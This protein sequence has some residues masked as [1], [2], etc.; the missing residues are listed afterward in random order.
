VNYLLAENLSKSFGEKLLFEDITF[1][2][3]KGQK[4]ALIARNGTGKSSLLNILTRK[5]YPDEGKV[6]Y[7]KDI[8]IAYLS[9]NP[10]LDDNSR[11]IDILFQSD[12]DFIAAIRDYEKCLTEAEDLNSD[13]YNEKL[14]K[15]IERMDLLHAW[16]YESL[17]KEILGKLNIGD[18]MQKVGQLSGGQK[19]KVALSKVLIEEVDLLILD[20][21][22]NHLDVE[23]IEWFEEYISKQNLSLLVVTHDRY[24][25]DNVCDEIIEIDDL[26]LFRYR[27]NY[28]YFLEK[29]AERI[30]IEEREIEK[31]RNLYR[32][33]LE[34][35]RR[36]PKA[37]ATKAKSRIDS[38]YDIQE[39]ASKRTDKPNSGFNVKMERIG[40][41]VL[42]MNNV[43]KTFGDFVA[44]N[45]FSYTFKKGERIG[46]V[47]K[48]GSGKTT[49][50]ETIMGRHKP[51]TGKIT[52]GQ[53]ISFGY[54]SQEGLKP[55]D[56]KRILDIVK[57]V[58]ESIPTGKGG[59]VSASQF[60]LH[61]GFSHSVQYNYFSSLSGGEKRRLYLLMTL[62]KNP[63][64]LILDEP[65][66]DLDIHTLSLLEDFLSKFAGCL[67]IVSHDRFFLDK[68][69]DHVFVFENEGRI[70][71][72]NG[73]YSDYRDYRKK[74]ESFLKQKKRSD[75]EA[76][77]T[78]VEKPKSNKPTYKQK[79]EYKN[80]EIDIS[81]LEK[82][83][84]ELVKRMNSGIDD[85]KKLQECSV[86]VGE[87]IELIEQKTERWLELS[88]IIDS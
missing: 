15:C 35:M 29:K 13:E 52:T 25:L 62:M 81:E 10:E 87:I 71:D 4:V 34:W 1:G 56:D 27:G 30:K 5:D 60:L 2:I 42:E 82:E 45:N 47:G 32:K 74:N 12:N 53:T 3:D 31:A 14:Q 26:K 40:G 67:I 19:K 6:T 68:L 84:S 85:N 80:L 28:S 16:D 17:V 50:L 63:N 36:M 73:N 20:E 48:N 39:K 41:K 8:N 11:I 24:F 69:V 78:A 64:F 58:A 65:T 44:V 86:R 83:Q 21:P 23:M 33:E 49:F 22:T 7:R 57:D 37:R 77:E 66:N 79:L 51:D 54:Y 38:F 75:E 18:I 55:K 43:T 88:E 72:F 9:Q 76:K 70:K 61:F 59:S 46:I